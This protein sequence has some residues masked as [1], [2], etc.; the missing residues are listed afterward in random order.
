MLNVPGRRLFIAALWAVTAIGQTTQAI[1]SGTIVDSRTGDAIRAAEIRVVQLS[2]GSTYRIAGRSDGSFTLPLLPPDIY[3]VRVEAGE[4]YQAQELYNLELPVAANLE[5]QFRL[6]PKKDVLEQYQRQNVFLP[7]GKVL[8]IIGPDVDTSR[9]DSFDANRGRI[10]SMESSISN[11]IDPA[12]ITVLPLEG[13]DVYTMIS[14]QP[15]VASDSAINRGVGVSDTGQ[16]PSSSNFMLDG[17]QNNNYLTTGPLAIAP[18]EGI[19]EF[20]LSTN[21]FTAEYGG[22]TGFLANA[23][24]RSGGVAWHGLGYSYMR[25]TGL[26][27]GDYQRNAAGMP[28]LPMHEL[29]PGFQ[30]GG[31]LRRSGRF[32][33]LFGSV[34]F[35][36]LRYRS[37]SGVQPFTIPT[38]LFRAEAN[39]SAA[40]L[41]EHFPP[42]M[43]AN[44]SGPTATLMLSPRISLNRYL[45][46]S[47]VDEV[48]G[49]KHRLFA[50]LAVNRLNRPDLVWSPY[51]EFNVPLV[52]NTVAFGAGW[53]AAATPSLINEVKVG[54]GAELLSILRPH[55]EV[56]YLQAGGVALP[57][58]SYRF[59]LRSRDANREL[60]D[61]VTW[62]RGGHEFKF[63][64]ALLARSID[65]LLAYESS[66][67]YIFSGLNQ[68]A[69][70]QIQKRGVLG[71]TAPNCGGSASQREPAVAGPESSLYLCSGRSICA[72]RLANQPAPQCELWCAIR[73]LR[74]PSRRRETN[75]TPSHSS[76]GC[77]DCGPTCNQPIPGQRFGSAVC[78]RQ[79]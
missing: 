36:A 74:Q 6:R 8:V 21:N 10:S 24:T 13:R 37:E 32:G 53:T 68:F 64:G 4:D 17:L 34:T 61:N 62:S 22:T 27:A 55:S 60:I 20:R 47:R 59:D 65:S 44:P 26:N 63:G 50:R 18:P 40:F 31:P 56:P 7:N 39:T 70:N 41:L 43:V 49:T 57:G 71:P 69:T 45:A 23:V 76:G 29:E 1:I 48:L 58:S 12:Q 52:Q 77:T 33:A 5:F 2:S 75:R 79:E 46:I 51:T 73:R 54:I 25:R 42:P 19:Q 28:K 15:G 30:T 11:V 67:L 78:V 3:R 35:D 72:G 14:T 38:S 9:T 16:R 66:G